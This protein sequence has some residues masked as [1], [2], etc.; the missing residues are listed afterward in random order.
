[1][2]STIKR[3][4]LVGTLLLTGA[5]LLYFGFLPPPA[6]SFENNPAVPPEVRDCALTSVRHLLR[7]PIDWFLPR[8]LYAIAIIEQ[9]VIISEVS[10]DKELDRF[11]VQCTRGEGTVKRVYQ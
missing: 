2:I 6:R 10:G 3:H 9:G 7:H 8:E 4:L 1:M 11:L 5:T